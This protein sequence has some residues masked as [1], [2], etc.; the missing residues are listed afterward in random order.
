MDI[1]NVW[2]LYSHLGKSPLVEWKYGSLDS[3]LIYS[4]ILLSALIQD[5]AAK[6]ILGLP[7]SWVSR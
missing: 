2:L 1:N 6:G 3:L 5:N 4:D 7:D